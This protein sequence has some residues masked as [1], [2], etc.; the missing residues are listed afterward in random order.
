MVIDALIPFLFFSPIIG[1]YVALVVRSRRRRAQR[2]VREA[3]R[4]QA[5]EE[6]RRTDGRAG[7]LAVVDRVYQRARR[8][9][10]A[11]IIWDATGVEQD[12]WFHDW[13]DVP[14]GAYLM[15]AGSVG[16]GPHNHN[17]SVYYV[18][19]RQVLAIV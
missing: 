3:Q 8:G 4:R 12:A 15:L 18:T 19:R 1:A 2:A 16:Y 5:V 17:P 13:S 7:H 9:A 14:A 10:K 11:I 6:L